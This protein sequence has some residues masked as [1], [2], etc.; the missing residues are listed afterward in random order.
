MSLWR[1]NGLS[2]DTR[3][4][5]SR[6][7]RA[8]TACSLAL[9]IA[10]SGAFYEFGRNHHG[11]LQST[12]EANWPKKLFSLMFFLNKKKEHVS[13]ECISR[14]AEHPPNTLKETTP[15]RGC[16]AGTGLDVEAL[17]ASPP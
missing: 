15:R 7:V 3:V 16:R 6:G 10:A 14:Q 5:S 17:A 1:D 13:V 9:A 8:G 11:D 12:S 2:L 4:T